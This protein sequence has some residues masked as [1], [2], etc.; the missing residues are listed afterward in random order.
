MALPFVL[1]TQA[2]QPICR[3]PVGGLIFGLAVATK[4]EPGPSA[5]ARMTGPYIPPGW[6]YNPSA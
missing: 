6:D 3:H 2:P 1:W 4:P 5:L